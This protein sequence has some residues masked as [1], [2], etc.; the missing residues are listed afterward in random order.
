M[1]TVLIK[2]LGRHVNEEVQI[3]G[4]LFNK[5]SSGKIRFIIIRDGSGQVQ[6]T[7]VKSETDPELFELA[8]AVAQESSIRVKGIVREE[9][10]APSGYEL[11]VTGLEIVSPAKDYPITLKEHGVEFLADRRH[12]WIRG[13][14]QASVLRIR[15]EIEQ[16]IRD[17][18]YERDFILA[19]TP[20]ITTLAAEGTT[21]LFE[22]DYHGE[23]AYLAQ[24]GQL[25]SEATAM[26]LG[27]VYNFG[28]VFRAEK[29]KTR[30]HL[31]EFWMVEAEMAYCDHEQNLKLQEELVYYI[32]QRVL[33]KNWL[34]LKT[35]KRDVNKL[36]A[37]KLPFPRISYSEAVK[38]LQEQGEDFK[39]GDDFGAPHETILSNKYESP[40]FVHRYPAEI[41][42]FYMKPDPEDPKVV[43]G[44]DLLAPE[45]YGEIIG[46]GQRI[47]DPELLQQRLKEHNLPEEEFQWYLDLRRYG[48][49]PHAGFGLGIE[50]TVAWICGL[51]HVREAI[52]FPRMLYRLRP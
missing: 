17:F 15:S 43:L 37:V 30:R 22:I 28:P 31:L 4:W 26:A 41:K 36:E 44:A 1:E 13:P 32:I 35:L 19:D 7:L 18:F 6:G 29:S 10:R 21:T 8:G 45:G 20:I 27:R 52:P 11:T 47:D 46:G 16:A 3:Q 38:F 50:R 34:E 39:W 12:L 42:A 25:Y 2:Y 33:K 24:T 23:K 40:V 49:V 9:P 48:S 5:R 14:R 51:E